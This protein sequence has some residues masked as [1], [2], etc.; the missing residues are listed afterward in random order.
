MG[1][2]DKLVAASVDGELEAM[3]LSE[4][5]TFTPER[6]VKWEDIAGLGYAKSTLREATVLPRLI[7]QIFNTLLRAPPL[8]AP[9]GLQIVAPAT[10]NCM[11]DFTHF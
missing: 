9:V 10:I 3:A 6:S 11:K 1:T 7:P 8:G 4:V 5:V 2:V